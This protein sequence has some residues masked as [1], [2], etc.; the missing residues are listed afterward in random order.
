[1][2]DN[3]TEEILKKIAIDPI[4]TSYDKTHIVDIVLHSIDEYLKEHPL[5]LAEENFDDELDILLMEDVLITFENIL[6]FSLEE[7]LRILIQEAKRL[8]F[9]YIMPRRSYR[10]LCKP[11]TSIKKERISQQINI[12]RNKYQPEQRTQEWYD[13]RYNLITASSA[14]KAYGSPSM[15]NSLIYEKCKPNIPR[16]T[17]NINMDSSLHWGQKYEPIS[18]SIYEDKYKTQIED[19]GC[20]QDDNHK[21][22]GASPDGINIDSTSH[23]YGRMLEI[24]NIVNR[25][26]TGIPKKDYWI[27]MQL[28]MHVCNLNECDFWETRFSEYNSYNEYMNDYSDTPF[29]TADGKRKGMY[30]CFNEN[31]IPKYEYPDLNLS[32]DALQEWEEIQM[33]KPNRIWIKNNYW[34]LEEYSCVL[35]CRNR[36]WFKAAVLL[37]ENIWSII[38]YER[39]HG[40]E[41][42]AP[43]RKRKEIAEKNNNICDMFSAKP[44]SSCLINLKVIKKE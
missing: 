22:L 10:H 39:I 24:K 8:Y 20:I 13:F 32:Q 15:V 21:F 28:Q 30:M 1:M 44:Q 37:L 33:N 41:H 18:V 25:K 38:E 40:Y 27:Q 35:V 23:L 3:S 29:I 12:L 26:I 2:D 14:G 17:T 43:N 9:L 6:S 16:K 36:I 19:F 42:R 34:K 11:I 31:D 5:K 7:D 4:L